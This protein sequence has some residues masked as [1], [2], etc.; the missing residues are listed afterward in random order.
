MALFSKNLLGCV[1]STSHSNGWLTDWPA[2]KTQHLVISHAVGRSTQY[3]VTHTYIQYILVF[4]NL[5]YTEINVYVYSLWNLKKERSIFMVNE[6]RKALKVYN[7]C[8][9]I[10]LEVDECWYIRHKA[11]VQ[12]PGHASKR[13]YEKI[14]LRRLPLS[15]FVAKTLRVNKIARKS[16]SKICC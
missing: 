6:K 12:I 5:W 11:I 10:L 15:R 2:D 3:N 14:F 4:G 16:F 7:Y 13:K 1:H 9:T 8:M